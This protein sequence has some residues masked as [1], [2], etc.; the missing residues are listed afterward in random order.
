MTA[1]PNGQHVGT[2]QTS[3]PGGWM[4]TQGNILAVKGKGM[5]VR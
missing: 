3:V 4:S 5:R 2:S 1:I